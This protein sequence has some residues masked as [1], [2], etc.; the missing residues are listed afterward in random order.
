MKFKCVKDITNSKKSITLQILNCG[1]FHTR[2]TRIQI[3]N[4]LK[5]TWYNTRGNSQSDIKVII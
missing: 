1:P 4:K 5:K 3:T 2:N